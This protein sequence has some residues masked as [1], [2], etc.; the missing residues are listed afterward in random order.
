MVSETTIAVFGSSRPKSGSDAYEQA[1]DLGKRIAQR[2]WTLCNG[3]YGGTMEASAKGAAEAAGQV[4]G[5]TCNIWSRAGISPFLTREVRMDDLY[6]RVR[7]LVELS[8]AYIVLP[9]GTGTL[10]EL[11]L[12]WELVNKKFLT[13]RPI[14]LI[15]DCWQGVIE[16]VSNDD[17][18][19]IHCIHQAADPA[20]AINLLASRLGEGAKQK[21]D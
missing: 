6:S 10:L 4:V 14:V 18:R 1:Y 17:P 9:G 7:T 3:G 15:G 11:A 5:V 2:G 12:V 13:G 20:Q 19:C 21:P 16:A 8:S